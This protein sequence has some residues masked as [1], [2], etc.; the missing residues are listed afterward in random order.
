M[1]LVVAALLLTAPQVTNVAKIDPAARCT[2]H[3]EMVDLGLYFL[4][5]IIPVVAERCR[6]ILPADAWL[7]IEDPAYVERIATARNEHWVGAKQAFVKMMGESPL[8]GISDTTFRGL[9]DDMP[10]TKLP[11]T[12]PGI[13]P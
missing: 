10:R 5:S 11:P 6:S 3:A 12:R 13:G 9:M 2:T 1:T 8:E 7:T 4:P